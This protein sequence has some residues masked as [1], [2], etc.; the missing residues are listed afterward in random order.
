MPAGL[1]PVVEQLL[2][3]QS[4]FQ[5]CARIDARR[6]VA[7]DVDQV[8]AMAI[9]R[10]VPEVAEAD[11]VQRRRRLEARDVAAELGAVLVGAQDDGQRVP[12]D[13]RAQPVLDRAVAGAAFLALR[14]D[15][16]AVRG[17]QRARDVDAFAPGRFHERVDQMIGALGTTML[18]HGLQCVVPFLSLDRVDVS[19]SLVRSCCLRRRG[20]D[21]ARA[22]HRCKP[23]RK[24]DA[25]A[26]APLSRTQVHD[27]IQLLH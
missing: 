22:G 26:A 4:P 2:F 25:N 13:D 7:L 24:R 19:Q 11:V 5:E 21:G 1:L 12:A 8:A 3:A 17:G 10:R 15:G 6:A 16:V 27:L 14:R 23:I 20:L 9:A 18:L